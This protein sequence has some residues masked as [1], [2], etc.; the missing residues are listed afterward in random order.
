MERCRLLQRCWLVHKH[1]NSKLVDAKLA[2]PFTNLKGIPEKLND[3]VSLYGEKLSLE[4][5]LSYKA[6]VMLEGNDVSSGLKWALFSNSVVLMPIPTFTSFAMEELLQP[7]F[8]YVPLADDLSDVEEK[9]QWVLD[10]DEEAEKIA[11]HGKLWISDLVLH[12]EAVNDENAIF[13]EIVRRY[14]SHFRFERELT[15]R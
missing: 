6:L 5:M 4:Q 14:R 2:L 11:H 15:D 3:G 12:P 7:W 9:M 13:D 1:S 8:H 10:H